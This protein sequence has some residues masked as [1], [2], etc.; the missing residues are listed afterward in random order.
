MANEIRLLTY[1]P[2]PTAGTTQIVFD[3]NSSS[4]NTLAYNADAATWQAEAETLAALTGNISV[5]GDYQS[6]YVVE[7]VGALANTNVA[8]AFALSSSTLTAPAGDPTVAV[9][10]EGVDAVDEVQ[11][12]T[13]SGTGTY[14]LEFDGQE[15]STLSITDDQSDDT[16]AGVQAALE[17]LS[18]IGSGNVAVAGGSNFSP[19]TITFQGALA[20]TNVALIT[21]TNKSFSSGDA[22]VTLTTQGVAAVTEVQR[23]TIPDGLYNTGSN[24]YWKVDTSHGTQI[25]AVD[26]NHSATIETALEDFLGVGVGVASFGD[27]YHY[28][29]TWDD[30]GARSTLAPVNVDM[31]LPVT[32]NDATTQEGSPAGSAG[33]LLLLGVDS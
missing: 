30:A 24:Q 31:L 14:T 17:A 7:F 12:H 15:T 13:F 5:S 10:T 25:E 26:T 9:I 29:V 11:E 19:F 33:S 4:N 3:G 8:A 32:L 6:G 28:T 22:D 21:V 2:E 16:P 23:I 18:N 20:G 1:D 27:N